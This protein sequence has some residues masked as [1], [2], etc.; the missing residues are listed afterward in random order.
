VFAE[1]NACILVISDTFLTKLHPLLRALM[2]VPDTHQAD[3]GT[4]HALLP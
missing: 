4:E 1:Q 2:E 3:T